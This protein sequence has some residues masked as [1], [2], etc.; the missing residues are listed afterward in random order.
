MV[1]PRFQKLALVD[2]V[3]SDLPNGS[4]VPILSFKPKVQVAAAYLNFQS[5]NHKANEITVI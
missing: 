5:K 2:Q 3:R 4:E 1:N